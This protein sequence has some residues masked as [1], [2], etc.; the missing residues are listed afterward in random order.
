MDNK[1]D[2]ADSYIS[3]I[4]QHTEGEGFNFRHDVIYR[5]RDYRLVAKRTRYE[6][7]SNAFITISVML[8]EIPELTSDIFERFIK[9]SF[10]YSAMNVAAFWPRGLF[11]RLTCYPVAIT[12]KADPEMTEALQQTIYKRWGAR[13]MPI[14]YDLETGKIYYQEKTTDKDRDSLYSHSLELRHLLSPD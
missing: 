8:A 1:K 5:G 2:T 14:I 6:G 10:R 13:L 9:N 11:Y 4:R 12:G 3:R 7:D